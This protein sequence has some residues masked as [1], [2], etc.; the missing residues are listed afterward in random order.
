MPSTTLKTLAF[1]AAGL[2][3]GFAIATWLPPGRGAAAPGATADPAADASLRERVAALERRLGEEAERRAALEAEVGVLR[4]ALRQPSGSAR[5]AADREQIFL[6]DA[7]DAADGGGEAGEDRSLGSERRFRNGP[8]QAEVQQ[9]R[10]DRLVEAGF[11]PDRAAWIDRRA[12]ELLVQALQLQYDASRNG[13]DTDF[14]PDDALRAELGDDE[15]ERYLEAL[16]RP[17]RVRVGRVLPTSPA[18]RAGLLPGDEV[19]AYAGRRVFD[20]RE[21][22]RFTLEGRPGETVVLDVLRDGQPI[23]LYLP[24]GPLGITPGGRFVRGR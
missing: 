4:E 17:T 23:Q 14:S 10:I 24:R 20:I 11:T 1:L 22:N 15:Y 2:A 9:R 7:F 5:S 19:V 3:A 12:A 8:T 18:E 6:D 13:E 16:G 21:L